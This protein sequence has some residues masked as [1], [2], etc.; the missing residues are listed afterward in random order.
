MLRKTD[1][2][3]NHCSYNGCMRGFFVLNSARRKI[4]LN[5]FRFASREKLYGKLLL[6]MLAIGFVAG[7]YWFFK[8]I[9]DY[10]LSLPLNLWDIMIPQFLMVICLT[11]FSM[12]VFSNIIA[13]ISTFYMS[14]DLNLLISMP[15]NT[16]EL[17]A[18]RFLQTTINS[19]W[20]LILFGVPI[21]IALGR[22]FDASAFYYVGMIFAVVP[23]IVIP[24]GI[25]VTVTV[26]LMRYF[27]ARKTY[28]FL[29]FVGVVFMAGLVMFFRFLEPEK[30]LGKK[31]PTDLIQQYVENLKI[32]SYWF[33]PS[34][35]TT[36][37]L[38]AGIRSEYSQ[39]A[40]W[41]SV[42]WVTAI[43]FVLLSVFV[44]SRVYYRGWSIASVGRGNSRIIRD[45][46]FYRMLERL[47]SFIP[48][49]LG[50]IVMKDVKIFWR[51][52]SQWTQ[53]FLLFA[54]VIV[55]IYNIRNLP[56]DS[57]LLKNFISALNIGLAAVVLAA[58]A[59]RFVFVTTS[60]E[61]K[62]FWLIKSAPINFA[63]FLWVKFLFF[64]FPLLLL[65]ETLI[66]ASNLFLSVD[67]FLMKLSVIGIFFLTVGLT[68]LGIG[69]GAMF[70]VFDHEN[71][72]ELATSTGAIYYMLLS[73]AYIG[74]VVMFGVRPVWAH[75]SLKFLGREIGGF[76][77][78]VC[79]AVV[80]L[81][82]VAVTLIPMRMGVASLRNKE[83]G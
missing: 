13:S 5:S 53:L 67:P 22:S 69:L 32:P 35:W 2:D 34:T 7:D 20:M 83:V 43:L 76:E 4:V 37:A 51:D 44:I 38:D 18:S 9:I 54:L 61:G 31:I 21:F 10:L 8:R 23:F 39:M 79:Y 58:I 30:F 27:P 41:V 63:G 33:L 52:P 68:G 46:F 28:Q 73:F 75:F 16:R 24:A 60:V 48:R 81:L 64:I 56:M 78:Y 14:Q 45:R 49:N 40:F 25:G 19:S 47:L 74:V 3:V 77:V 72:A 15:V 17:F 50:A 29:S 26:L 71:I 55:Y 36:K 62:S 70:P 1:V 42:E 12:L 65:S 66:I 59:V 82:T 6:G 57:I 80:I 11:F